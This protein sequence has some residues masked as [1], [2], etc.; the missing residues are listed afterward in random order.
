M[1]ATDLTF[2]GLVDD[3]IEILLDRALTAIATPSNVGAWRHRTRRHLHATHDAAAHQL[4]TADLEH[5]G[6]V[7]VTA[8]TLANLLAP[9]PES[10]AVPAKLEPNVYERAETRRRERNVDA[11]TDWLP[12]D[13]QGRCV[14]DAR[15]ALAA[16]KA[17]HVDPDAEAAAVDETPDPADG[18]TA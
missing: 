11:P 15:A 9:E 8:K 6:T 13:V 16:A 17:V 1:N 4:L 12:E 2:D 18:G 7:T 3:A 5:S 10:P 14:A